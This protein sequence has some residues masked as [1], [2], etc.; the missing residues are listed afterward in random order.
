MAKIIDINDQVISI[1]TDDGGIKEI[2][3]CDINFVPHVGDEVEVFE[4]ETKTIV[5]KVEAKAAEMPA[6]G[7][8]VNVVNTN[9]SNNTGEAVAT[10]RG[11]KA[12]SKVAYC[13]LAFFLGGLGAHKFYSGRIG[14][15]VVYI[16]FCWTWIPS[17]VAFIE[18]IIALC[19]KSD[20]AGRILV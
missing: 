9:A 5:S 3:A 19:K 13:L 15:G 2:R 10:G 18:F 4:T 6:G 7:I 14:L 11:T 12:V 17:I 20:S 8:N 16:I 1:G